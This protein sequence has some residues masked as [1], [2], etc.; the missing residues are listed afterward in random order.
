MFILF[1]FLKERCIRNHGINEIYDSSIEKLFAKTD[2]VSF[3][4][5]IKQGAKLQSQALA[6]IPKSRNLN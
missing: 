1:Y 5:L 4:R 6:N 3:E 2:L